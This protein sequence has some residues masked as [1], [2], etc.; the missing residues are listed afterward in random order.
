MLNEQPEFLIVTGQSGAGK[1]TAINCLE[2]IGYFCID[3]FPPTLI[4]KLAEL[5]LHSEGKIS[6]VAL[7]IDIR[8]RDFFKNAAAAIH[9]LEKMGIKC[10][11]LF[12][13]A[14]NEVIVRRFKE[15]RRR[16]PLAQGGNIVEGINKERLL[17]QEFK[18]MA[19]KIIDT[20]ALSGKTL[21]EEIL[22]NFLGLENQRHMLVG[23]VSFGYKYGMPLDADLVFDVR[24]LPN[25]FYVPELRPLTGEEKSV[26]DYALDNEI[27]HA[28]LTKLLDMLEF[29][30]GPYAQEGKTHLK[31]AIGC[32]G[33]KHRSVAV[34]QE[35]YQK[36][37]QSGNYEVMIEHRDKDIQVSEG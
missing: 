37:S 9:E 24:F 16:H 5:C 33:G 20:S 26:R 27:G 2:D 32:T 15:T 10:S 35:I 34:A 3:N 14:S 8:G 28:F 11:I 21:K 1:T 17:L 31:I 29:L 4:T 25:P 23:I 6:K 13:Q 30:V 12:L 22:H 18:G 19:N 36:L 7:V